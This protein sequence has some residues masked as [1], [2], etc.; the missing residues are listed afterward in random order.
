MYVAIPIYTGKPKDGQH[1]F[2]H[3]VFLW[4]LRRNVNDSKHFKGIG[5]SIFFFDCYLIM[6]VKSSL[7]PQ[8]SFVTPFLFNISCFDISFR[9]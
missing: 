9:S 4:S 7:F 3:K 5:Y 8:L 6:Y 1:S 2:F